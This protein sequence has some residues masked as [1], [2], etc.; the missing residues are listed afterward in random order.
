MLQIQAN[1]TR[2]GALAVGVSN[3]LPHHLADLEAAVEEVRG[4]RKAASRAVSYGG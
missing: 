3:F 2:G 1:G 4:G